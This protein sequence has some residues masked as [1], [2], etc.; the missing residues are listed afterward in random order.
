[1]LIGIILA[2]IIILVILISTGFIKFY[3]K[4]GPADVISSEKVEHCK[5][6]EDWLKVDCVANVAIENKD[7][8][9]C[10]YAPS[11]YKNACY[12]KVAVGLKDISICEKLSPRDLTKSARNWCYVNVAI[13]S[14]N[15]NLCNKVEKDDENYNTKY[16][17]CL[18][19]IQKDQSFCQKIE[20]DTKK[21][22]CLSKIV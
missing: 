10:F 7:S 13:A 16:N 22:E 9:Y 6:L 14:N 12:E 17:Y 18:G 8:G 3:A 4:V 2:V 11:L 21:E 20:V 19:V 1:M 15:V 5:D